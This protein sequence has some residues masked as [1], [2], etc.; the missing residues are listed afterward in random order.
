MRDLFPNHRIYVNLS[1]V[2]VTMNFSISNHYG[3]A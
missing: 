3:T 1:P 2:N